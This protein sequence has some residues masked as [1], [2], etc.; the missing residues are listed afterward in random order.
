MSNS[1]WT[2]QVS[3]ATWRSRI[4]DG[5]T[6][7]REASSIEKKIAVSGDHHVAVRGGAD[8]DYGVGGTDQPELHDMSDLESDV[9]QCLT[10]P[11]R[12]VRVEQEPHAGRAIGTSRS[13]T[14]AAANSRA[15]STS[16]RS[17]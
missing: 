6:L 4:T 7:C 14:I 8:E 13:F 3:S 1:R 11:R 2:C 16:G 9:A 15:A 12:Q 10:E 5:P 17:R